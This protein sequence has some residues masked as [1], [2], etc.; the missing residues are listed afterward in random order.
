MES[1]Y[2]CGNSFKRLQ[3]PAVYM[4][5]MSQNFSF[6]HASNSS[7]L[8]FR[9]SA[10]VTGATSRI[11]RSLSPLVS[12]GDRLDTYAVVD[13]NVVYDSQSLSESHRRGRRVFMSEESRLSLETVTAL[14]QGELQWTR[15][16]SVSVAPAN[17]S[18]LV[19]TRL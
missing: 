9:F 19:D 10:H 11:V 17:C 1:F 5:Y 3:V 12:D 6:F 18:G 16:W 13:H 15:G 7:R 8:I 4:S 14:R 2:S